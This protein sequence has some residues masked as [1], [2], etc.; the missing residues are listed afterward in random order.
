MRR[1]ANHINNNV[2]WEW[3]QRKWAWSTARVVV[4]AQGEESP[5]EPKPSK[6]G[7]EEED[8]DME[9]GEVSPLPHS[10]LTEDLPSVDNLFS[11]QVGISIG[12]F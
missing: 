1:E 2:P 10:P 12:V 4:W 6:G 3:R 7:V 9:E 5:S 8:E 11:R